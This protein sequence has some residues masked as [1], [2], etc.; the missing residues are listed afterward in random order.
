MDELITK[1]L[2]GTATDIEARNLERWRS[3]S[4]ENEAAFL[5]VRA[6]WAL[7][8]SGAEGAAA[9]RPTVAAIVDEAERR[10]ARDRA[11]AGWAAAVR[12]PWAGYGLAAA[13]AVALLLARVG[14][15]GRTPAPLLAPIESTASAGDVVTMTLS[16]GSVVRL[17]PSSRLEFP[18][19]EE[20]RTVVLSG[21]AFFAVAPAGTPF[22]VRTRAGEVTVHGT[23]FE[24]AAS[25]EELRLVVVEGTVSVTGST[26]SAAVT[27]GQVA[28]VGADGR[29]RVV[30]SDDVWALLDW[31]GGLLVFQETPLA[32]VAEEAGRHYGRPVR[33]ADELRGRRITA[34]FSDEPAEEVFAAVCLIAGATCEVGRDSIAVG[35]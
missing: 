6:L 7:A 23:R 15:G 26:G 13:A 2:S 35:R 3:E 34:W 32:R 18:P 14:E 8:R 29:P 20:A 4:A 17:A 33:V 24:V 27:A 5:E 9:S 25:G 11:W 22:V 31:A 21:R 1:V 30:T 10:R 28:H 19:S 12:S 16:D